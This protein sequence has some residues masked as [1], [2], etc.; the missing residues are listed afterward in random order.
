MARSMGRVIFEAVD[1]IIEWLPLSLNVCVI[2]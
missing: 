2:R 1:T